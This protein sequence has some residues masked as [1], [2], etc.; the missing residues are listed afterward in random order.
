MAERTAWKQGLV[1]GL[2][3]A[4]TVAVWFFILDMVR[5]RPF[6]TPAALGSTVFLGVRDLESVQVTGG[7]ILGY[8]AV[9]LT[10]FILLGTLVVVIARGA[11]KTPPLILGALLVFVT[12]QALFMGVLAIAAEHLL[13]ALAWW[14]VAIGNL[15]AAVTMGYYVWEKDPALKEALAQEPFD[16]TH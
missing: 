16:R 1:V 4:V 12:F 3:G 15:L 2:I 6:F 14:G 8:S 11:R 7:I 10:A 9:H 13:G 5:G